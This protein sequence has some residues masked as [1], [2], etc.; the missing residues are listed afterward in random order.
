MKNED[1]RLLS[2]INRDVDTT[3]TDQIANGVLMD[4]TATHP[5]DGARGASSR[6][7]SVPVTLV[8]PSVRT[9]M[10]GSVNVR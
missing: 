8:D 2:S 9:V 3:P 1:E 4:T 6:S 5:Q 7:Q 10:D